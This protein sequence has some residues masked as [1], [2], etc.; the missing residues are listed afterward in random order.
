[1]LHITMMKYSTNELG[2]I[3]IVTNSDNKAELESLGFVDHVDKIKKPSK[4]PVKKPGKATGND[5]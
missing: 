5:K 4:T 2:Y 3:Q 1:M